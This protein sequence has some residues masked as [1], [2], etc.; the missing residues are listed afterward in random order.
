MNNKEEL[1]LEN[2]TF[3]EWMDSYDTA[4]AYLM[5]GGNITY[6][7]ISYKETEYVLKFQDKT[8]QSVIKHLKFNKVKTNKDV[9]ADKI[10]SDYDKIKLKRC[11][12]ICQKE[13]NKD[14][15]IL[16]NNINRKGNIK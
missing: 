1:D 6:A 7:G 3:Y 16:P 5:R 12:E 15:G 11:R 14:M 13:Y 8:I 10:H 2:K 4:Y 9:N